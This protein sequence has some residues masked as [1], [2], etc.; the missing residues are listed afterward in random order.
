[1]IVGVCHTKKTNED[2]YLALCNGVK[3]AGDKLIC[4]DDFTQSNL[5]K[6]RMVSQSF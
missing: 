3:A 5:L 2:R 6:K 1:M 4:I